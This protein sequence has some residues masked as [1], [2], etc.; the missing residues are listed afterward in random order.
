MKAHEEL[1]KKRAAL[2]E[3]LARAAEKKNIYLMDM[4]NAPIEQK[5]KINIS[6]TL[7][8]DTKEAEQAVHAIKLN[9][10]EHGEEED[11]SVLHK[12]KETLERKNSLSLDCVSYTKKGK[13]TMDQ[14]TQ[15]K[16][17]SVINEAVQ[18]NK[19]EEKKEVDVQI[20]RE[21]I[22]IRFKNKVMKTFRTIS[23]PRTTKTSTNGGN[24]FQFRRKFSKNRLPNSQDTDVT[25]A[26]VSY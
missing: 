23:L 5:D 22:I 16:E 2:S 10:I 9:E 15:D 11:A 4:F 24:F 1:L 12:V 17:E 25:I 13:L 20:D 19:I 8:I 18:I 3:Q 26:A 21:S 6:K 14:E 7:I